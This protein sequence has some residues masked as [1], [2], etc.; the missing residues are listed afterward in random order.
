M[1]GL[2]SVE[3][4]TCTHLVSV[5]ADLSLQAGTAIRKVEEQCVPCPSP[6]NGLRKDHLEY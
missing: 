6:G 1:A 2:E 3:T 4:D 5:A